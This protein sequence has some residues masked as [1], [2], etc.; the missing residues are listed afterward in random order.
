MH[1]FL[2]FHSC[3]SI[4]WALALLSAVRSNREVHSWHPEAPDTCILKEGRSGGLERGVHSGVGQELGPTC[5]LSMMWASHIH[6]MA[7]VSMS[8]ARKAADMHQLLM[9]RPQNCHCDRPRRKGQVWL[10]RKA[11]PSLLC[12]LSQW[13]WSGAL[14]CPFEPPICCSHPPIAG[15]R[16]MTAVEHVPA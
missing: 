6:T 5:W 16:L 8:E 2:I 13:A 9:S 3:N 1:N 12:V 4:H 15:H 7:L 11:G 10:P 14:S